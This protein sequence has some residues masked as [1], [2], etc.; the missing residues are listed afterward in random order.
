MRR[1]MLSMVAVLTVVLGLV[2]DVAVGHQLYEQVHTS[3]AHIAASLKETVIDG[4]DD[5]ENWRKNS[6]LDTSS[7]YVHVR[8]MRA[9]AKVKNYY[10]PLA[11]SIQS[12]KPVPLLGQLRYKSNKGL[13]YYEEVHAKG[14]NYEIWQS[15][16]SYVAVLLRVLL[17]TLVV[18]LLAL[19]ISPFFIRRLAARLTGP[20][21]EL[22]SS[23]KDAAE[24]AKAGAVVLPVLAKPTE[25]TALAQDF[26]ALLA[27]LHERQEQQKAFIMN[28]AHELRTPIATIRSHA[29]LIERHGTEHPEIVAKSV[30]YITEESRQMQQLI[31]ELLQL[32]RAD[33]L[34]L[35]AHLI[36][37]STTVQELVGKLASA[38]PNQLVTHIT[39]NMSVL[40]NESAIEQILDNFVANAAKYSATDAPI[41]V[42]LTR[43]DDGNA[44]LAVADQGRGISDAEKPHVFERFYRG[45]DVRGSVSGTGLGLAIA[46]QLASISNG[47][48]RVRDNQPHGTIFEFVIPLTT[49]A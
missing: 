40:G 46:D 7:T 4:N 6:T 1:A 34:T 42:S 18:L 30:T 43:S 39:P 23:T 28:A 25:V 13:F 48:L 38:F 49:K 45:A 12:A 36:D 35:D 10:S 16:N 3:S 33:R 27:Q 2:I 15:M 41:D 11:K 8:N 17:V 24:N 32:S 47:H 14:I 26:N 44:V 37:L 19:A 9:D 22:S 21:S 20:L 29:Q 5:W 31:E